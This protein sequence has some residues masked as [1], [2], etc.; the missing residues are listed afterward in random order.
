MS[1]L[2]QELVISYTHAETK[3]VGSPLLLFH[4]VYL[5][6]T[7]CPVKL[8]RQSTIYKCLSFGRR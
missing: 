5:V 2:H 8:K 1:Y 4:N 7:Q 6:F 3:D